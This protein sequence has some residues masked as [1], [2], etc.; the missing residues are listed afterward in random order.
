MSHKV[1]KGCVYMGMF[2]TFER[3]MLERVFANAVLTYGRVSCFGKERNSLGS[4]S[5]IF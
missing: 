4:I 2:V 5:C 1:R 3:Q